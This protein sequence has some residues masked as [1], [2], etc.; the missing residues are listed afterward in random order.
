MNGE[1]LEPG[2]RVC[3]AGSS[4][5]MRFQ[6]GDVRMFER[7]PNEVAILGK[8]DESLLVVDTTQVSYRFRRGE[9]RLLADIMSQPARFLLQQKAG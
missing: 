4:C 5:V 9:T 3:Y 7:R 2:N 1:T 6:G 8:A